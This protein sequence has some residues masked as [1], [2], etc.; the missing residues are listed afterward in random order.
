MSKKLNTLEMEITITDWLGPIRNIVVPTVTDMGAPINFEADLLS[1]TKAGY[2]TCVE[3]KVSK[4]DL[5]NDLKKNHIKRLSEP[6]WRN[7]VGKNALEHYYRTL[8]HF[9]YAVPEF[10]REDALG[11]IPPCA[12]LLTV[13]RKEN[14]FKTF[15]VVEVRKPKKLNDHKWSDRQILGVAKFGCQRSIQLRKNLLRMRNELIE[16]KK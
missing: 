11:Q 4:A 13:E 6:F 7:S 1:I 8:K 3:I 2:A 5:R 14:Y 10:L 15:K 9:Y 12:G 16:L